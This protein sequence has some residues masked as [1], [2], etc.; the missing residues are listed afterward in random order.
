MN[1][2][3][4][5]WIAQTAIFIALLV[6][7][8]YFSQQLGQF[9]TGSAVNFILIVACILVGVTAGVTVGVVS[10]VLA[11]MI[12]G[13]PVFPQLIPFVMVGNAVL[14]IAVHY[15]FAKSYAKAWEFSRVRAVMAV[16]VGSAAKFL[17]LW[18][19]V[20]QVALAFIP[21]ILPQ[22][23]VNLSHMFSWPQLVTALI[24]SS[25]AMVVTPRLARALKGL[26]AG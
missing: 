12:T 13:R 17:V 6:T 26:H 1:R 22:Q 25:L 4:I 10:P 8:Q 3:R 20:V 23:V 14:V 7:A 18:V 11:F 2:G 21:N 5:L 9:V 24:G 15:I 19:G 16:V